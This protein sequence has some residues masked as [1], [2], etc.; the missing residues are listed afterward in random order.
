MGEHRG[1]TFH[2]AVLLDDTG[3]APK[4]GEGEALVWGVGVKELEAGWEPVY[5]WGATMGCPGT[6]GGRGI[7]GRGQTS[8][9]PR[10]GLGT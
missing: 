2:Q 8:E 10:K 5:V 4:L 6:G 1:G 9:E 3:P 7:R